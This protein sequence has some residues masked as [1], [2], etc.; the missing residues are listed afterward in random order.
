MIKNLFNIS[1]AKVLNN[2]AQKNIKGGQPVLRDCASTGICPPGFC[3]SGGHCI[4]E[5][6]I[7][8]DPM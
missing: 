8:C 6:I 1:G 2:V 7:P 3:C 5:D 4:D